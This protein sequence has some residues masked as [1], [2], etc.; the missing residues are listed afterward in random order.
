MARIEGKKVAIVATHGFEQSELESPRE[1]LRKA[2][3]EVHVVGLEPGDIKGWDEDDWGRAV[4]VDRTIEQVKPDE[5]DAVVV[6]GGQINPDLLRVNE[7]AVSFVR[8]MFEQGKPV[9]AICHGPWVL[10]EAGIVKGRRMT[11]YKSIRTDLANAGA[12]VVDEP[13]VVDQGLVTSRNPGD[14][15]AFNRKVIEEIAEGRHTA[16]A[17]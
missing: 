1:A 15:E 2:G 11:C 5:Y 17:A 16:R 14:L 4:A 8:T 13:V 10:I 6:P 12:T 9:A 7:R 3:A